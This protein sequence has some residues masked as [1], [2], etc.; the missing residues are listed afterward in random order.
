MGEDSATFRSGSAAG[1]LL[2]GYLGCHRGAGTW[3][4]DA[5]REAVG[6]FYTEAKRQCVIDDLG[7]LHRKLRHHVVFV[8]DFNRQIVMGQNVSSLVK[9]GGEFSS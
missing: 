6:V 3:Q 1:A 2:L 7:A 8:F 9:D 4:A 5:T